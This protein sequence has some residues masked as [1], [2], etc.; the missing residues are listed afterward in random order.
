MQTQKKRAVGTLPSYPSI[1]TALKELEQSGF[2]MDQISI[3]GRD[4]H[5]TV[6]TIG[7]L[8]RLLMGMG[9]VHIPSIGQVLLAGTAATAIVNSISGSFITPASGSL[10]VALTNLGIPANR[11]KFYS[12]RVFNSN[13]IVVIDGIEG[14]LALAHLILSDCGIQDWHTYEISSE[15]ARTALTFSTPLSRI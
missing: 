2:R 10:A 9:S 5:H 11:A 1:E 8:A 13:Y 7:P 14:E 6:T 4:I 3:V 12:D 15:M